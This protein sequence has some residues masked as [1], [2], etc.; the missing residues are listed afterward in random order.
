H[1]FNLQ[2]P[3]TDAAPTALTGLVFTPDRS[4]TATTSGNGRVAFLQVV[5][6]TEG[7][8]GAAK[9]WSTDGLLEL[10]TE[11]E[12]LLVTDLSRQS[13]LTDPLIAQRI[14]A[15]AAKDGSSM[16][17]LLVPGLRWEGM[18]GAAFTLDLPAA[19]VEDLKRLIA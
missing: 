10:L 6:L 8:R 7:E 18:L 9:A 2:G 5:G 12:P 3:I 4:V 1:T 14:E 13:L 16:A 17:A 11:R 15:G 19:A